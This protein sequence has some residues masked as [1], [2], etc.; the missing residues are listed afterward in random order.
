MKMSL[1]KSSMSVHKSLVTIKQRAPALTFGPRIRP[2][3]LNDESIS[4]PTF[5]TTLSGGPPP[6]LCMVPAG[7]GPCFIISSTR[8]AAAST[9][10]IRSVVSFN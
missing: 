7:G 9:D 3:R 5:T 4:I 1:S 6:P 8:D 10:L 2:I